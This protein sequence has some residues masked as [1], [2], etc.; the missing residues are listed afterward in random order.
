LIAMREPRPDELLDFEVIRDLAA[1]TADSGDAF[2]RSV[3]ERFAADAG[4]ALERMQ[5]LAR[6]GDSV[7]LAR[8]AHRLK[9][10]SGTVGARLLAG[11]CLEIERAAR[12]GVCF[13][14][15]PMIAHACATLDATRC[16]L[17]AYFDGTIAAAA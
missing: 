11:E 15:P 9:G 17:A 10:S 4:G 3:L 7:S 8:E 12:A 14:T 6:A 16:G 2:L 5:S 13:V 1:V